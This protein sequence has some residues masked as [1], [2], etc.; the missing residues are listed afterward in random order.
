MK[1]NLYENILFLYD[2]SRDIAYFRI[3]N[4]KKKYIY[5]QREQLEI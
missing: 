2:F 1:N 4:I 3:C 5:T